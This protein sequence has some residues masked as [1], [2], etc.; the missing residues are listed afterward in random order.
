MLRKA[1]SALMLLR[2]LAHPLG[3]PGDH[4]SLNEELYRSLADFMPGVFPE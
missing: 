3:A 1:L 4:T 2:L